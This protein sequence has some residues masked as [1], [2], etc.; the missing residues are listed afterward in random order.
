MLGEVLRKEIQKIMDDSGFK[1]RVV[2]KGGRQLK[3]ILQR[4]DVEP[5]QCCMDGECPVCLTSPK[6]L[7]QMESVGYRIWCKA[8][9]EVGVEARMDGETGRTARLRCK[10]H[11]KALRS[12]TESSNLREHC[13]LMHGGVQVE[14]GCEVVSRFP[15]DPLS[16]Q[17]EE[18]VRIDHQ[19]GISLND[20][21]EFVRPA[22]VRMTASRM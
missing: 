19:R 7:C 8:C 21:A 5:Q 16:R 22:S 13:D 4:S 10:E 2:E 9:E 1:V 14:F 6:G 11:M 15:G 3:S 17:I 20:K 18:A 12:E